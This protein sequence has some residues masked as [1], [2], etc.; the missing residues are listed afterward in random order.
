MRRGYRLKYFP[1]SGCWYRGPHASGF[2]SLF[3]GPALRTDLADS[4]VDDAL[5]F[6]GVGIGVAH[7]DILNG[8]LKHASTDSLLDEF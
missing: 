4:F 3:F 7:P 6:I 5:N 2:V 8:A 1:P